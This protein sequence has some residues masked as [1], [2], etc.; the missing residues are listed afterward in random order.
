MFSTWRGWED[1]LAV[2]WQSLISIV[3]LQLIISFEYIIE[4][5]YFLEKH[6]QQKEITWAS[7]KIK[8]QVKIFKI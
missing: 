2:F 5:F 6:L 4:I 3:S 8:L 1:T 7:Q